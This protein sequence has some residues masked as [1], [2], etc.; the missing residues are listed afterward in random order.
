[1]LLHPF[2]KTIA[3]RVT[4]GAGLLV[5]PWEEERRIV[6]QRGVYSLPGGP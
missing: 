6:S 5:V 2:V 3:S 4:V 1:M